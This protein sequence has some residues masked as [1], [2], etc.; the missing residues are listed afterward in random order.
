MRR[1][2]EFFCGVELVGHCFLV[3]F[4]YVF[5]L[6]FFLVPA[7]VMDGWIECLST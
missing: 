2:V 1:Y 3:A 6:W 7:E 5:L 4:V